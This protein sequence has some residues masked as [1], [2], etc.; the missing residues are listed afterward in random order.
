M[1]QMPDTRGKF[2]SV[3]HSTKL[4]G[5]RYTPSVCYPLSSGLQA[6]VERMASEGLARIYTERVRFVT[7][8]PYPVQK[9]AAPTAA[10]QLSSVSMPEAQAVAKP[11]V[12]PPL[13]APE[14][15]GRKSGR[16]TAASR[17]NREFN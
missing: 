7:G 8:V 15:P 5:V 16:N 17:T 9:P 6:V 13:A 3:K 1:I 10:A 4:Q 2:F 11:E 14:K 12:T